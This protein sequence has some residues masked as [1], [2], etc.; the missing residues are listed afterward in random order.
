[1]SHDSTTPALDPP[2]STAAGTRPRILLTLGGGGYG[3]QATLLGRAL[4]DH[5]D[6][7]YMTGPFGRW[8]REVGLPDGPYFIAPYFKSVV[9]GSR[10]RDLVSSFLIGYRSFRFLRQHKPDCVVALAMP[11]ALATLLVSRL[12]GY[13]TIFIESVTR[14]EVP[15]AT[16][17]L[18]RRLGAAKHVYVQWPGLTEKVPGTEFRGR[19]F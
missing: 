8:P 11:Q 4:K 1:M 15:S 10:W 17:K 2:L 19:V 18:C 12:L 3:L 14:V 7:I 13:P 5:A 6:L 9:A 16:I